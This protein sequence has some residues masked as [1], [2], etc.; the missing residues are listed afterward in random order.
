VTLLED[1]YRRVLRLLPASYREEREDEMVATYL[2]TAGTVSDEDGAR[3]SWPE[4]GSVAALAVRVRLGGA[5]APPR[6]VVWGDA[7]RL[8]ALLALLG[9]AAASFAGL[10]FVLRVH[11]V[12]GAPLF[13]PGFDYD[14]MYGPPG[15]PA[16]IWYVAQI[17]LGLAWIAAF[18]A[19]VHDFRRAARV[20][21][22]LAAIPPAV[23]LIR[24]VVAA[25]GS[26]AWEGVLIHS[27][28]QALFTAVAVLA[29]IAGFHRDA[30][31]VRPR[32]WLIALAAGAAGI[33]VVALPVIGSMT[34]PGEP[35]TATLIVVQLVM[36]AG[37]YS[38]LLIAA[39]LTYAGVH[40]L[41]PHRRTPSWPLAL[42]IL[43][44]PVFVARFGTLP[45]YD[46]ISADYPAVFLVARGQTAGLVL[47]GMA[48]LAMAGQALRSLPARPA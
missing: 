47:V 26:S 48:L 10:W 17:V 36:D 24:A 30:P 9:Q 46:M 3:P 16:R 38:T 21:V 14:A 44:V 19:L 7:V 39:G 42:A 23:E 20:L 33:L 6:F 1:R 4:I 35:T 13:D 8:V 28:P 5:G 2:E 25:A 27:F 32:P 12:L 34:T 45:A 31:A 43:A 37:L 29:L 18:L 40:V 41:A 15:S 11:G 22:L